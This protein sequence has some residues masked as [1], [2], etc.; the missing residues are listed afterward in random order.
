MS[1]ELDLGTPVPSALVRDL[2]PQVYQQQ[3]PLL[4]DF[5]EAYYEWLESSTSPVEICRTLSQQIDIDLTLDR[6]VDD[7]QKQYL[8]NIPEDVTGNTRLLVKHVLD[9][10]RSKGSPR[11]V[12]LL[13]RIIF[14][15]DIEIFNP[16]E[17]LFKPSDGIW[18]KDIYLEVTDNSRNRAFIG[19]QITGSVS[20][21]T[22]TVEDFRKFKVNNKVINQLVI[23]DLSRNF[24]TNEK[25]ADDGEYVT[26]PTVV[27]SLSNMNITNPGG[28]FSV[29]QVLNL[30]SAT[31]QGAGARLRVAGITDSSGQLTAINIDNS[32]SGYE[33]GNIIT[34]TGGT[35]VGSANAEVGG[36]VDTETIRIYYNEIGEIANVEV[37]STPPDGS[38]T[39]VTDVSN[40]TVQDIT[41]GSIGY[42]NITDRGTGYTDAP[43][44]S[45]RN[46]RIADLYL[47][48]TKAVY[49]YKGN[50]ATL[51]VPGNFD[52]AQLSDFEIVDS[53][54]GY[55]S[56]E[57]LNILS[58]AGEILANGTAVLTRQGV[59]AG[60]YIGSRSFAS[61]DYIIQDNI[62]WQDFSYEIKSGLSLPEYAETVKKLVH[63]AGLALFGKVLN[64]LESD[65]TASAVSATVTT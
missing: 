32:G 25:I 5:V 45:C 1:H 18:Q 53:G 41:V 4:V 22:A 44:A 33:V 48:S 15:E 13:F 59:S 35:F 9:L 24:T 29:G 65:T 16:G 40:T 27:G 47:A 56:G 43:T 34:F 6:F 64:K 54:F 11:A 19:R 62:Y 61:S 3:S 57:S 2:F 14:N 12:S 23:T 28:G 21:A 10:Y 51:T 42:I 36:I 17:F 20:G 60:R 30:A 31:N 63:P 7:F 46:D 58:D 50:D 52:N 38:N 55:I 26:G 8:V 39:V 49:K 37:Y